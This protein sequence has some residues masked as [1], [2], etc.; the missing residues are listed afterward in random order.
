M[1]EILCVSVYM[2]VYEFIDISYILI[3]LGLVSSYPPCPPSKPSPQ[4]S[5]L[6]PQAKQLP[7]YPSL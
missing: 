2:T 7:K 6:S 5:H 3:F 1:Q 4:I